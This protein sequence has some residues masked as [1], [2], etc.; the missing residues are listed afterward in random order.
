MITCK[1]LIDNFTFSWLTFVLTFFPV[2]HLLSKA[3]CQSFFTRIKAKFHL[4]KLIFQ[5][6]GWHVCLPRLLAHRRDQLTCHRPTALSHRNFFKILPFAY[7]SD[8]CFW[9]WA[10]YAE[11]VAT[12]LAGKRVDSHLLLRARQLHTCGGRRWKGGGADNDE[13]QL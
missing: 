6:N 12:M 3:K 8:I 11:Y 5:I 7:V 9:S 2:E 1:G 13:L 10:K 4:T